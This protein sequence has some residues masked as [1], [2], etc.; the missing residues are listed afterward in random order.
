MYNVNL[1]L[2]FY[3]CNQL[4]IEALLWEWHLM[5]WWWSWESIGP[6]LCEG[7]NLC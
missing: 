6:I 7:G 5:G 2:H 4:E 1:L 3:I